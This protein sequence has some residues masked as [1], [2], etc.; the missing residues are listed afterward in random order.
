MKTLRGVELWRPPRRKWVAEAAAHPGC[1][2][3]RLLG[4]DPT[5]SRYRLR[6]DDHV[7]FFDCARQT[8]PARRW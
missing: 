2:R 6:L 7:G 8:W 5:S 1:R 3:S 4:P